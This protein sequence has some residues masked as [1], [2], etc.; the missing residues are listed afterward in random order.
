[1]REQ[2]VRSLSGSDGV[3]EI[4]QAADGSRFLAARSAG[5]RAYLYF[6]LQDEATAAI[7]GPVY[8]RVEYLDHALTGRLL[9]EYDSD[10]GEGTPTP[11]AYRVAER[12]AGGWLLGSGQWRTAI[13]EL[14]SPL[15]AGRQNLEADFRISAGSPR[16][17]AVELS[18][19]RPADWEQVNAAPDLA[20]LVKIGPGGELIIGGFDPGKPE[21][22]EPQTRA[23]EAAAPALKALG[24]TSSE[25]YVRWNLCEPEEGVYDWSVYDAYVDVYKRTG[26]KWVPFIIIGPAYS[27][28]DW[29]HEQPGSQGY[30]CL[31]HGEETHVQSLWNPVMREHVAR[32]LQAFCERYRDSG[33]IESILLGVTGNYGE[34]IYLASGNDWT[35]GTHGNYHTH[36]GFW[37]GDP[38]AVESFRAWLAEKYGSDEKLQAAWGKTDATLE[39]V[40]PF[41][42]QEAPSDRAWVDFVTWYTGS[43][44]GYAEFWLANTRKHFDGEIYLCTGGHAPPEHGA[45]FADQSKLAAEYNAGIRITNEANDYTLNFF[46]TR[47]VASACRQYGTYYAFEPAGPINPAGIV[48]RVYN[49]TASGARGL[50]FYYPNLFDTP[51]ATETFVRVGDHFRQREPITE[52]AVY[53]PQT[54]VTLFGQDLTDRFR[55]LRD[56]FDFAFMS[57]RQI[58]DGGLKETKALVILWGTTSEAETWQAIHQWVR[59]G[60][61]LLFSDGLGPLR[62]VGGDTKIHDQVILG[63]PG[64]GEILVQKRGGNDI[65]Y[66][67]FLTHALAGSGRLS[68][69]TRQMIAADGREDGVYVTLCENELLWLNATGREM[70]RE[71]VTLPPASIVSQPLEAGEPESRDD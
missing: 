49:A 9:V 67:D 68:P 30:V 62:T 10:T 20:P 71:G 66:R 27:L 8:V 38:Y 25:I 12:Q 41:L 2:G 35:A 50:H 18:T 59:D 29:Y 54:H 26:L 40:K 44:T 16:I 15:F 32:F 21:D 69:R 5:G 53:Y 34:T 51:Q 56:R 17:R 57:D 36:M 60:G 43:M 58:L 47:W 45:N 1:M 46:L 3:T 11:T 4:G 13:F 70:E 24:V 19:T 22:V 14:Q 7:D 23:L 37:A 52:I 33:V 28:P 42:R 48:A 64:K 61:L 63:D 6:D 55:P 39:A 65:A 31:E